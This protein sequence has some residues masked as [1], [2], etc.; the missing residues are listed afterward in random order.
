MCNHYKIPFAKCKPLTKN[1]EAK[2]IGVWD[3]EKPYA[4]F[5]TVGAKRYI[6]EYSDGT[7]NMTVSGLNKKYAMPYLLEENDNNHDLIFE[8]FGEGMFIPAGHTGKLT[9]TYIEEEIKG[10]LVDYQGVAG[11]FHE[12]SAIHMEP[13][14]YYMSLVGDY[15]KFLKGVQYVE[16]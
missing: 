1:G 11:E 9:L 4:K 2:L 3:M 13:Q 10:T 8:K 16:I 5:K 14:S 12:L 15:I 6:Y 7:I